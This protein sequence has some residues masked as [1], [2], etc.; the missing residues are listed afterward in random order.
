VGTLGHHQDRPVA[1]TEDAE[2][3]VYLGSVPDPGLLG[4]ALAV[5]T[6]SGHLTV[7][8]NLVPDQSVVSLAYAD[9]LVV[10]ATSISGGLGATPTAR[11]AELFVY[12][13]AQGRLVA[14]LTPFP[15]TPAIG[16]LLAGPNGLVYGLTNRAVFAYDPRLNQ[17]VAETTFAPT[18]SYGSFSWGQTTSL[19]LG[20]DG[21]LYG[22][23]DGNL[24]EVNPQTLSVTVLV[25][26]GVERVV[27]SSSGLITFVGDSG[28]HLEQVLSVL[29][30]SPSGG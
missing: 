26:G 11:S 18:A 21:N 25:Q 6:P 23:V 17:V 14:T 20:A 5:L 24:I 13:P 12:S 29:P 9:G 28:T 4:G 8:R 1:M 2:G 7:Y 27:A 15:G 22:A 19:A 16:G 3:N 30:A 10:G